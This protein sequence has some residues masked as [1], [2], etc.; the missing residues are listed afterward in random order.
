M[1]YAKLIDGNPF[2]APNPI[3][4]AGL[5]YGNPPAEVYTAEGYKP[6][7]YTDPPQTEPGYIAVPGWT[8]TDEAIVQTWTV[9][10]EPDEI[11]LLPVVSSSD[12][13]KFLR[14]VSGAWAAATVPSAETASF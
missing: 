9:E 3:L 10:P 6:V 12:N 4:H 13:D 5:W 11:R 14:V 8:E 1:K 7:T 2:F